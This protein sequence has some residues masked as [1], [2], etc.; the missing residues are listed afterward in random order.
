MLLKMIEKE[1]LEGGQLTGVCG[2]AVLLDPSLRDNLTAR[3]ADWRRR[4]IEDDGF[5]PERAEQ[6]I[7]SIDGALIG[8]ML[9]TAGSR[10]DHAKKA[11]AVMQ[12]IAADR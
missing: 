11:T 4:L 10:P 1:L 8:T 9:Y 12:A 7:L 2:S 5:S 6:L 3:R